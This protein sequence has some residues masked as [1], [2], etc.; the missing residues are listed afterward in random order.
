[1]SEANEPEASSNDEP[2]SQPNKKDKVRK[3]TNYLLTFV[4]VTL[5]FSI[6]SDRLIPITDNARVKG[7]IV[8]IK[9]EVSGKV[10]DI[11]VQP[12]QLVEQGDVL[13]V[14]DDSDYRIAVAQAEQNLE[15]AGQNV[16]AQ[17][18]NIASAQARLTSAIVERQNTDLQAKRVLAMADKG[19][20]SKSDADQSKSCFGDIKS[21]SS[22]C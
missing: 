7:Y 18:A 8:P 10:L 22:E 6:V 3:V 14:L 4:A 12:N 20:V 17:T 16:G 21:C 9:P 11:R 13:A 5:V 15:I 2:V 1:M 19:V